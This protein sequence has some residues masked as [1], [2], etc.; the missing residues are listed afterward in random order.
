M[1]LYFVAI[2]YYINN[3]SRQDLTANW[4]NLQAL[5]EKIYA[6]DNIKKYVANRP[7]FGNAVGC[8]YIVYLQLIYDKIKF[9]CFMNYIIMCFEPI[10]ISALSS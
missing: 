7:W 10:F 2:L 4:P 3:M 9:E 6:N 1:D 8:G 5:K